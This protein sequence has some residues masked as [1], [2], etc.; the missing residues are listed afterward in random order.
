MTLTL[1]I[2]ILI[3]L[4]ILLIFSYV[5]INIESNIYGKDSY[6]KIN[7]MILKGLIKFNYEIPF[8]DIIWGRNEPIL[9]LKSSIEEKSTNKKIDYQ[10]D[11]LDFKEILKKLEI[12][13]DY[14]KIY[15]DSV[16][17]ILKKIRIKRINWNT[18]I[19][20]SDAAITSILYGIINIIK[21]FIIQ[22]FF[23]DKEVEELYVNI[24]PDFGK[25]IFKADFDC[26][27]KIKLVDII[28]GGYKALKVKIKGG[29]T[30]E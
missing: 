21:V 15:I 24:I 5:V 20:V 18:E 11:Y 14:K 25:T 17:Y 10:K 29:V 3:I 16:E 23:G 6:L 19:G 30:N 13:S 8:L 2:V 1:L 26:I 7:F 28:I 12:I 9:K 22:I 4:L 27:I